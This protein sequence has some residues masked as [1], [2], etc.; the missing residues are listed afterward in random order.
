MAPLPYTLYIVKSS[1]H[2]LHSPSLFLFSTFFETNAALNNNTLQVVHAQAEAEEL[3]ARATQLSALLLE[4]DQVRA[5][6]LL[7]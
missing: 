5:V 6:L 4:R 1:F 3:R 2:C 7:S